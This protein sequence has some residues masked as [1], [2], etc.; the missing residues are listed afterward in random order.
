MSSCLTYE[1]DKPATCTCVGTLKMIG[2]NHKDHPEQL[3]KI[4]TYKMNKTE[5]NGRKMFIVPCGDK[6]KNASISL[7]RNHD[8][9]HLPQGKINEYS[10]GVTCGNAY[11]WKHMKRGDLVVFIIKAKDNIDIYWSII[12]K[13]VLRETE[14]WKGDGPRHPF[15]F[16]LKNKPLRLLGVSKK[17]IIQGLPSSVGRHDHDDRLMGM[18]MYEIGDAMPILQVINKAKWSRK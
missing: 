10:W 4:L 2:V 7:L 8:S 6:N 3:D 12:D 14:I 18:R 13:T 9:R 16:V 15:T 11:M 17:D 5:M 1:H